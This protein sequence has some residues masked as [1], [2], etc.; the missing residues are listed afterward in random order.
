MQMID[1]T[2]QKTCV[3]AKE[4]EVLLGRLNHAGFIIPMARHFLGRLREALYATRQM[5][6]QMERIATGRS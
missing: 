6:Y 1:E 5:F 3:E 2:R 4:I